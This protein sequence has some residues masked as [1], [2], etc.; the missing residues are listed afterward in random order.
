MVTVTGRADAIV[1]GQ[2][3]VATSSITCDTVGSDSLYLRYLPPGTVLLV[4]GAH[5][6]LRMPHVWSDSHHDVRSVWTP[7]GIV[8]M[9]SREL[10]KCTVPV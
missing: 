6:G 9:P 2:L 1:F 10:F 8:F 4:L 5:T 7:E 3:R